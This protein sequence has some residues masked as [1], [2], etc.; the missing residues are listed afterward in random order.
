MD[1][2]FIAAQ[3]L[4]SL[5]RD[6]GQPPGKNGAGDDADPKKQ[7]IDIKRATAISAAALFMYYDFMDSDVK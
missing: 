2:P 1:I 4:I 6:P 7:W 5:I 3:R